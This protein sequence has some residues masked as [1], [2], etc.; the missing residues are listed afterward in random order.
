MKIMDGTQ[1]DHMYLANRINH[2]RCGT[3]Q[4]RQTAIKHLKT[5]VD[6]NFRRR[7]KQYDNDDSQLGPVNAKSK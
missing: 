2:V 5:R 6:F 1:A 3:E 4:E 7:L